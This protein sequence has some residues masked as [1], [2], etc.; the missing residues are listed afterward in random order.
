MKFDVNSALQTIFNKIDIWLEKLTAMLPNLVL[1]ILT[2]VIFLNLAR[3][4]RRLFA[5]IIGRA[6]EDVSIQRL[7]TQL[8][9]YLGLSLGVFVVLEIL[10]LDKAVT[11]LIAGLGV[12]GIALGFA[13]QDIAA[14]FI[15]GVILAFK[16]PF[17]IGDVVEID[18]TIGALDRTDFRLTVIR[19]FQGQEVYI[20]NKDVIQKKII[21][22]TITGERRIDLKIGISYGEDLEQVQQVTLDA[23]KTV[24][25][26]R[27]DK[28]IIFD[29]YEFEDS[30]I[31]FNLRFWITFPGEPTI[32][33]IINQVFI[34]IKKAYDA[35]DI[36]IPF[37][38]RT[39]D[40]GVK[41]GTK[42]SELNLG[43]AL[44]GNGK[45]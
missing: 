12:V 3:L 17:N 42:L 1:A 26:V 21:N 31:N 14:N 20:P 40:F 34:A 28:D 27:T 15:A 38:I 22:Y 11:S 8:V 24:E 5:R 29:Y 6:T 2:F 23:V 4:G 36:T 33:Q 35:H 43:A 7:L 19:T 39:L 25:G 45:D 41:G 30:S 44:N 18:G 32:L 37:P 9:Y 10:E 13:F 16:K